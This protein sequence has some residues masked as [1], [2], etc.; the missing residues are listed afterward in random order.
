GGDHGGALAPAFAHGA[1]HIVLA[2][3]FPH[4]EGAGVAD[5]AEARI[6]AQHDLAERRAVPARLA[7]GADVQ[8][9]VGHGVV[10]RVSGP[11]VRMRP[12]CRAAPIECSAHRPGSESS[13][14]PAK[15]PFERGS[16]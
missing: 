12:A 2:A 14:G 16:R 11:A 5:A 4:L 6:E 8:D 3:A 13:T 1:G 15:P 7:G 10:P 9:I